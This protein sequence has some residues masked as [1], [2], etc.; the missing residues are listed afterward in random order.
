MAAEGYIL[1]TLNRLGRVEFSGDASGL[2]KT[3]EFRQEAFLKM[4]DE[5]RALV[6]GINAGVRRDEQIEDQAERVE[7][8]KEKR[9]EEL[10][11][12][13]AAVVNG[14]DPEGVGVPEKSIFERPSFTVIRKSTEPAAI[15]K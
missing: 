12:A 9:S 4:F 13:A 7:I 5:S 15:S 1:I 6:H 14:D 2:K 3:G 11:A 8:A 10:A